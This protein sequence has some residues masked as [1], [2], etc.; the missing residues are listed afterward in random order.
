MKRSLTVLA[1]EAGRS[2]GEFLAARMGSA[3]E[4][5]IAAGSVHVG[6]RR[7][8]DPGGRLRAGTKV[9]VYDQPPAAPPFRIV[10]Q[11]AD[12]IVVDKPAGLPVSATRQS[13]AHALDALLVAEGRDYVGVVHRLDLDASGLVVLSRRRA[14]NRALAAGFATHT[15]GRGYLAL[16]SGRLDAEQGRWSAPVAGKRAATRFRVLERLPR[17]TLLALDLETGRSHQIRVHT[18]S[19]GHPIV[20][21]RRHGGPPAARLMLHA[22]TLACAGRQ[23]EAAPPGDFTAV[24]A[25]WRAV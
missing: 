19:T 15:F 6:G 1:A 24:L 13:A 8:R 9:V 12:C 4:A 7:T 22:A 10:Y 23:F 18:A 21:D 14:A 5:A 16:V 25:D 11:D 20:G 17:A 2:L 3:A